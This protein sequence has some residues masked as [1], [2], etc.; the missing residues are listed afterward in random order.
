MPKASQSPELLA[1][2]KTLY[3]T[4]LALRREVTG[5]QHVEKSLANASPFSRPMQE[6][7]TEFGWGALWSRPGLT[8]QQRSLLNLAMLTAMGKE[9]ELGVHVRGAVRNGC[10]VV[11]I[12]EALLQASGYAGLPAGLAAFRIAERVLVEEVEGG[13][14][15]AK[16]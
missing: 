15:K 4:G 14:L 10:S 16:L 7:A 6:L 12:R 1:A 9:Q 3:N 5:A 11:E 8:K 13:E 2:R